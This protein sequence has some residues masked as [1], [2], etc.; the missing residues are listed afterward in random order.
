MGRQGEIESNPRDNNEDIQFL[1]LAAEAATTNG[2]RA[3]EFSYRGRTLHDAVANTLK[4]MLGAVGDSIW[5]TS[6][7]DISSI[8]RRP[9]HPWAPS[10]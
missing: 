2:I 5:G 9:P 4:Q 8:R 1:V 3:Y 10:P 6:E 7:G